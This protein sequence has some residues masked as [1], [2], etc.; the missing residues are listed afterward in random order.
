ML[1]GQGGKLLEQWEKGRDINVKAVGEHFIGRLR[2]M[3]EIKNVE[4][5]IRLHD[6]SIDDLYKMV[7]QLNER[8]SRLEVEVQRLQWQIN[9]TQYKR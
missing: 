1:L 6:I 9:Q 3:R 4:A 2:K 7:N 5:T 8:V